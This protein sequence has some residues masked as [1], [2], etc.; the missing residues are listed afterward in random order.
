M[1]YYPGK[2]EHPC[3]RCGGTVW[4]MFWSIGA[5]R[6]DQRCDGCGTEMFTED[7]ERALGHNV[8]VISPVDENPRTD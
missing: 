6:L 1:G 2:R 8:G 5:M 7:E 3:P 4:T